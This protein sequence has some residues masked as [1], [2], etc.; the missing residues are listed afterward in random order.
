MIL[1]RSNSGGNKISTGSFS[2]LQLVINL[3]ESARTFIRF[4]LAECP[5]QSGRHGCFAYSRDSD[6]PGP[7]SIA[8]WSVCFLGTGILKLHSI[9]WVWICWVCVILTTVLSISYKLAKYLKGLFYDLSFSFW[10]KCHS[11]ERNVCMISWHI[12]LVCLHFEL[13]CETAPA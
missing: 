3:F 5:P 9:F 1:T 12:S 8:S 13:Y 10:L 2:T 11:V 4:H 7:F 6:L